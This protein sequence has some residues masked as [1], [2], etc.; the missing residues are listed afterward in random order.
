M[1]GGRGIWGGFD[2]DATAQ[3]GL[4]RMSH[5]EQETACH[6]K[7]ETSEKVTWKQVISR[8]VN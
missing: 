1:P 6:E 3:P 7:Y 8:A 4:C 5:L 2:H